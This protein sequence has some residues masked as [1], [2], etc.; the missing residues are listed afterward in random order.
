MSSILD[1][2]EKKYPKN[3]IVMQNKIEQCFHK[4]TL[5]EKRLLILSSP[6]ARMMDATEKD[7]IEI[8]AE[9]FA[10]ECG[11]KT[12]SAYKQMYL[13]SKTLLNRSFS[14][15]NEKGKQVE[16][17]WV[18]RAIYDEGFISI[19]FPDEVLIMLKV[20]DAANPFTK[21]KKEHVLQLKG[22][23]SIDLYHLAKKY[24]SMGTFRMTLEDYKLE[25]GLPKSYD[26]INNL[27]A[28]ALEPS[29]EEINKK[30]DIDITYKNIKR[31]RV[32]VGLEFAVKSKSKKSLGAKRD[33]HTS[34]MFTIDGLT[35]AQLARI[36]RNKK[37][38]NHYNHLI[39]STSP[40]NQDPS[41]WVH[42]M[43]D[44]I[45]KDPDFFNKKCPIRD[46]LK[47]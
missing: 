24:E 44:R 25:L 47:D 30:T 1:T 42:E 16:V 21:Y 10:E 40:I 11:I 34:D 20:F 39:P 35:D 7:A 15:R 12:G 27:K 23:Y 22:E 46:Y 43:V 31:G 19:C 9:Q 38:I 41:L 45:K 28:R 5:D 18:I 17:T 36:T 8:T 13:A 3:L 2:Y 32:V 33:P 6:K 26:R 37:F 4:M 29:I 14:Y